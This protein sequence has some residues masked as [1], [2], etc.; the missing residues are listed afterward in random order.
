MA[1]LQAK[2][3]DLFALFH[4]FVTPTQNF[5]IGKPDNRAYQRLISLY[6]DTHHQILLIDDQT[7]NIHA[8]QRHG[9]IGI[10]Y[11]SAQQISSELQRIFN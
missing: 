5:M 2:H 1:T 4:D 7:V 6:G 11:K 10:Q 9:I 8:A 3:A